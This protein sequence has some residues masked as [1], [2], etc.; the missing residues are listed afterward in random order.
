MKK[1]MSGLALAI[2][3]GLTVT[4]CGSA[5]EEPAGTPVSERA[6]ETPEAA[7]PSEAASPSGTVKIG[8]SFAT[9]Q[10]PRWQSDADFMQK[11]A[12]ELGA[13]LLIQSANSDAQ[14]QNSQCENLI[15]QGI[16]AL[17]VIAQDG[18][19]AG[20]IVESA[21]EAGIKV[22][23]CDRLIN[24]AELDYYTSFD[25]FQAGVIQGQYALDHAPTGN[26]FL[27]GGSP[28]D[29]NAHLMR[30][31]QLSVLQPHIDSGE[32]KVVVDQWC[33]GW[34]AEAA[35]KYV[36][37]GLSNN[38]DDVAC[39]LTSNDDTAGAAIQALAEKGLADKVVVTGLDATLA[40]CQRI[41]EGTQDMSVYRKFSLEDECAVEL[42]YLCAT[43]KDPAEVYE[44][45]MTNNGLVDVPSVLLTDEKYMYA[46]TEERMKD[47]IADGW[48]AEEDIY[49]NVNQ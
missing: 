33:D 5:P 13:E 31:G 25:C 41:V 3:M 8:V 44:L 30:E 6:G 46:A 14:L 23:A 49:K 39:V 11:K 35:L 9:L 19:T 17:I 40:A 7:Q 1:Q 22:I 45:E 47:I 18:S 38:N 48:L 37:D 32:I 10:E 34:S 15:T 27:I 16:D 21:H 29:N 4:A 36:E 12:E 42:A 20:A 24:D 26:Y 43:G 28:T 2:C